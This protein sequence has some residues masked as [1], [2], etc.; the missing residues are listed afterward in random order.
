MGA[1]T[2]GACFKALFCAFMFF[3]LPRAAAAEPGDEFPPIYNTRAETSPLLE[4]GEAVKRMHLP[5]GFQATLFAGEP[6]VQQPIAMT[7]DA[8]GRLWV[9]ENYTYS[10]AKVNFDLKLRDRILIFEDTNH[11]G[12]FDRRTVFWDRAQK[13][14]GLAVGLGGV[15]AMCPPQ[16][17]FI[18][19]RTDGDAPAGPPQVLLDG[20]DADKTRHT[21]ANG[22]KFGP[23]GW[24]YGRSG[25]LA[26]SWVGKPGTPSRIP[27]NCGIW[28]YHPVTHKFE[29]VAEGTTNPWGNDWDENGQLFFINTVIGHLWHVIPGAYY[30]RMYGDDFDPHLY[31][32]IGQTA[33]HF[34]WD[35]REKWSDIRQLGVTSGT[36]EAGGGHAHTGLMIYLGDNWPEEYRNQP[37]MIN[38]HGKR[39]NHDRIERQGATYVAH[40]AP[41]FMTTDDPWFRGLDLLYGPDGGVYVS[42]WSDIGECHNQEAIHRTSGRI[43]KI[44]LGRPEHTF[45]GDLEKFSNDELVKLQLHHNDWFVRQA[46]LV[47]QG[48]FVR[49]DDM[50][51]TQASLH[52]MFDREPDVTRK[53]RAMWCLQVTG[54]ADEGWLR[55][56][57]LQANEQ[58]RVWAIQL[59]VDQTPPSA[60]LATE[61]ARLAKEDKSGLVLT[62]LA[63]A[64]LRVA[65]AERW[66]M[67]E[68][69]TAHT[70]FQS[71]PVLPLMIWYGIEPAVPKF[72]KEAVSLADTCGMPKVRRLIA[73]RLMEDVAERPEGA[74]QIVQLLKTRSET[75]FQADILGGLADALKGVRKTTPPVSWAGAEPVLEHSPDARVRDL[76]RELGAVFG[77]ARAIDALRTLAAD[78]NAGLNERREALRE[79]LQN[80]AENLS[81]LLQALLRETKLAPDAIRGL[82]ALGESGTAGILVDAYTNLGPASVKVEAVNA[83]VSRPPFATALLDAVQRGVIRRLD[84]GP[85]QI[86]QMRSFDDASI[87]RRLAK[88]WPEFYELP[89]DKQPLLARYKTLLTPDRLR[90]ASPA[91]GRRVFSQVCG[92]CHTLFGEGG[93]IG[94]DL[95]GSDRGNLDYLL[96]NI[97]DPSG[98]VPDG[99]KV[100]TLNLRDG[101]VITGMVGSKTD[102]LVTVQ[103]LTEKLTLPRRE[104]ESI[105]QSQLSMM[106]EGLLEGMSPGQIPNLIAYLMSP[107]QVSLNSK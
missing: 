29:V 48:R 79:L 63:S 18:P 24:L 1:G 64:M 54:G 47:L 13:L 40:H 73:R 95:T 34:H 10:E 9:A 50:K 27:I 4:P 99:Y 101:R 72:I 21:L 87:N 77:E 38:F 93:K 105:T 102:R 39:I 104:I 12:R 49:G 75:N 65:P 76:C 45:S 89:A 74:A 20:W 14:T 58:L 78:G 23:D 6:D 70:E 106:P 69:L 61:F 16:L 33:D 57:L 15:F 88:L 92:V 100:S 46:R 7:L 67:A 8:R 11:D 35:T 94:P 2:L 55:E 31:E 43:Y 52:A 85:F 22:L 28:R 83:L 36:S 90:Q 98:I 103:T 71:D 5:P 86:R 66:P 3:G 26:T 44:T 82:A 60:G 53:L 42:D 107:A 91:E 62:F 81:P 68:A 51:S 17:L 32:L 19:T 59:L 25:I 97:L 96:N 30:Q 84:I 80:R 41:D 37:F 56:Q